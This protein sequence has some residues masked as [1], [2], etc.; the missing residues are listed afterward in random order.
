MAIPDEVVIEQLASGLQDTCDAV[1]DRFA[2][3]SEHRPQV[4][5]ALIR[6]LRDTSYGAT[7][8]IV[9]GDLTGG[10][11]PLSHTLTRAEHDI[12]N[13]RGVNVIRDFRREGRDIRV[14][15]ARTMSS[16]PMWKYISVRRLCIFIEQSIVRGTRWAVFEPNSEPTWVA[17][18]TSIEI[19][20][21]TVWRNGALMGRT[22]DEAFFV[23][24]DRTTM[25]Q[26]DID[27]G[28]LICL[29]GV[30]PLRPAEFVIFRIS[31]KTT[32]W[33]ECLD[34]AVNRLSGR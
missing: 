31:Q 3:L 33:E 12:L 14:W 29:I 17:V 26:D 15:G 23:K 32:A 19:F 10:L 24:C 8:Y 9:A 7:Y 4:D 25:T 5:V 22:E 6:P 13:P 34:D 20:L 30:A 1:K 11:R 18:R 2:V 27:E 21:R 28:R 16:D